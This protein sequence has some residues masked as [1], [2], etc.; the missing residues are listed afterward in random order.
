MTNVDLHEGCILQGTNSQGRQ[1]I[2]QVLIQREDIPIQMPTLWPSMCPTGLHQDPI[3]PVTAQLGQ[4]GMHLMVYTDN[5]L[6][7]A[8]SKEL[9]RDHVIGLFYL[10]ENLGFVI[11]KPKCVLEPT[12]SMELLGFSVNSV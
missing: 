2:P 9:A 4:L 1:N 12:Q 3:K 6:I 11:S 8:E 7:L 10:L 5:T